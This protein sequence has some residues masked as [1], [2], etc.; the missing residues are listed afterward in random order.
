[1]NRGLYPDNR[2]KLQIFLVLRSAGSTGGMRG[3]GTRRGLGTWGRRGTGTAT[4]QCSPTLCCAP[5]LQPC[6]KR[7][8]CTPDREHGTHCRTHG[9]ATGQESQ[10]PWGHGTRAARHW[11]RWLWQSWRCA[12]QPGHRASIQAPSRNLPNT[13]LGLA[14]CPLSLAHKPGTGSTAG[15]CSH[16]TR[17]CPAAGG[18]LQRESSRGGRC[19]RAGLGRRAMREE[20]VA[21]RHRWPLPQQHQLCAGASGDWRGV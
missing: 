13:R 12:A 15:C 11:N 5:L 19:S 17:Q 9:A 1:M 8:S 4:V 7:C 16:P 20:V 14:G 2:A 18:A 6:C 3:T 10:V 21:L